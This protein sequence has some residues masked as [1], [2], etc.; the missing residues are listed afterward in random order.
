MSAELRRLRAEHGL[1]YDQIVMQCNIGKNRLGIILR[2][3]GPAIYINELH[4][5]A[6]VFDTKHL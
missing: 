3:E 2:D 4:E 5:L 1:S 6:T